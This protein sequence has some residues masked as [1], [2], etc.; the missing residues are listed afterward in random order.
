MDYSKI[1]LLMSQRK[2]NESQL[3]KEIGMSQPG[4][5]STLNNGT[6]RVDTLERLCSVFDVPVSYFF[7]EGEDKKKPCRECT[8]TKAQL[9]LLKE[10][11]NEKDRQIA[12]L[13]QEL[14]RKLGTRGNEVA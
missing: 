4:L 9:E 13:N 6:M 5:K 8:K 3:A 1:R 7:E 12:N 2:F 14:G 10:L 11:L